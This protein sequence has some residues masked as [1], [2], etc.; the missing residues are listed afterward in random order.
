PDWRVKLMCRFY[1]WTTIALLT[2]D[3]PVCLA[4]LSKIDR[5]IAREPAYKAK[6][7]YCLVVLGPEA[8]NRVWLVLDRDGLY[9]DRHGDGALPGK[10]RRFPKEYLTRGSVFQVG[11]IPARQ[12]GDSF[13]L[14]VRVT[15]RAG[16]EDS[17]VIWCRPL[18]G[19]GFV[20]RTDGVLL[21]ADRP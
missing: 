1:L 15:L 16:K 11:T 4:D 14:E 12:G 3:V 9:A 6:P 18:R 20:Q 10:E 19:K 13:S 8:R 21:F 7:K 17:H 5:T 2:A